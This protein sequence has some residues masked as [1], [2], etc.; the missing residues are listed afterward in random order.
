MMVAFMASA[1]AMVDIFSGYEML[2]VATKVSEIGGRSGRYVDEEE[3]CE[4]LPC[5][6]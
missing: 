2:P 6:K 1:P 3:V 4:E 5:L